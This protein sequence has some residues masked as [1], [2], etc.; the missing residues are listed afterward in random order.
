MS[1]AVAKVT[2]AV[3]ELQA[4]IGTEDTRK[5]L[6]WLAEGLGAPEEEFGPERARTRP[7]PGPE[8]MDLQGRLSPAAKLGQTKGP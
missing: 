4:A 7:E 2:D 8:G 5:L 1:E 3:A 6:L